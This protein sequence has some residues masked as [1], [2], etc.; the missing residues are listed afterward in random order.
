MVTYMAVAS[1]SRWV[2]T[3]SLAVVLSLVTLTAAAIGASPHSSTAGGLGGPPGVPTVIGGRQARVFSLPGSDPPSTERLRACLVS[4]GRTWP[5]PSTNRAP[6]G[7]VLD[8][9]SL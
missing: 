8:K 6:K 4:S 1:P 9:A 2:S 3:I 5:L 7:T